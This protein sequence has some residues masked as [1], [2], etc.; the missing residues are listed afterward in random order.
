MSNQ[1]MYL[2]IFFFFSLERVN[3]LLERSFIGKPIFEF[4]SQLRSQIDVEVH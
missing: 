2:D 1:W 4:F 3:T